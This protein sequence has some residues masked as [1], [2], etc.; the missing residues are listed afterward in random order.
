MA[1]KIIQIAHAISSDI[2]G[3][4]VVLCDDGTLWCLST[5]SSDWF[6]YP[7]I[8]QDNQNETPQATIR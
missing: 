2:R 1:R 7:D 6:K 3:E 5:Y 8:P 4:T